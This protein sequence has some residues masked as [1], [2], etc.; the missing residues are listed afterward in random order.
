MEIAG[1]DDATAVVIQDLLTE[2]CADG[3]NPRTGPPGHSV[4]RCALR[5]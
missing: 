1:A 2:R 5:G 4:V 3:A